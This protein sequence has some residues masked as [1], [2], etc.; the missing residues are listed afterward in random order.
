MNTKYWPATFEERGVVVPFTTPM[1]A[2]AR[3][4][5]DGNGGLEI[6]VPGLSGGSG[7]YIIGWSGVREVFRMSVHDRAF[8]DMIETRKAA[9]PRDM[10]RCAHEIAMTGLSGP[11][12]ID[13]AEKAIEQEENERLLT[14]YYL[15]NSVVKTLAKADVK[16]SVVEL[17]SAAGQKKVRGIMA[18]IASD[19]RVSSEQLYAD[20]EK[21]SDLIA[22]V[23]IASM[24]HE[25][26][27]RRL[28]SRLKAFRM[29]VT[30]WGKNSNADPDGLAF[31]VAD[32][33]LLTLDVGRT[34]IGEIDDHANDLTAALANWGTVGKEISDGM[35]RISWLLDGWDHV[36]ELWE[37]VL[38]GAM[39][40]QRDALEEIVRM[41]PLVPTKELETNNGKAWGDLENAM[42]KFVKPLQNWQSG[43]TDIELQLRIER[44]RAEAMREQA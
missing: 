26:R 18:G 4:R 32:V 17:S 31:L 9:T 40:E 42:R 8:H 39:H 44:R 27:L 21:W 24:P 43:H 20:I 2:F 14:N 34:L 5:S 23:G 33:A 7:V 15:V 25:C 36:I 11:D 29:N 1:L 30:A 10:R 6:I 19:L 12:A 22:P 13:A 37:D 16:L 3:A 38:D 28:M 41:L 35:T